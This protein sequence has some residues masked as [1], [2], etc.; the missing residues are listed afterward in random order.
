MEPPLDRPAD[1]DLVGLKSEA[2]Q[3]PD[4]LS[5]NYYFNVGALACG[6]VTDTIS[7]IV[8]S[9]VE[10]RLLVAIPSAAWNR[11]VNLRKLPAGTLE[12]V[13]S[14]NV[15]VASEEDRQEVNPELS[16][17]VW[18]GW[19]KEE[20]YGQIDFT[21]LE[22]VTIPFVAKDSEETC[23]PYAEALVGVAEERFKLDLGMKAD[24][25]GD[26][27]KKFD[28]LQVSLERLIHQQEGKGESG[29]QSPFEEVPAPKGI[30][31]N[32]GKVG[33]V[34]S[35]A[36]AASPGP[37]PGLSEVQ[38]YPGLDAATVAAAIQ[39]GV[40][41]E[42]LQS[43]S[44]VLG[45]SPGKLADY[46]RPDGARGELAQAFEDDAE[47]EE[48][49]LDEEESLGQSKQLSSAIVKLTDI[50]AKLTSSTSSSPN[51]EEVLE[52]SGSG[53]GAG[54]AGDISS[55]LGRK[56]AAARR[57][58]Q[59][60]FLHDP[61]QIWKS[62][63]D[64]MA[65][66]FNMQTSAPNATSAFSARGWCEHRSK[67]QPYIRTCRWVWGIAGVLD[68]LRAGMHD[69]ARARCCLLIAAAEQESLDHGSFLLSQEFLMEPPVPLSSFQAHV[70]PDS[71]EMATTRLL[72]ARWIEA[73]ADRLKQVDTYLEM[74][75][76]VNFKPRQNQS[77][78]TSQ[79]PKGKGK[80]KSKGKSKQKPSADG[81]PAPQT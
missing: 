49:G 76:K 55:S 41:K 42:H 12:K 73:Y 39:A 69:Q 22:L 26:L 68:S 3:S 28:L 9:F 7:I 18:L 44:K 47:D 62:I 40:P 27:E 29:F 11:K 75:R 23:W 48:D 37:P 79:E 70:L 50:M 6:G 74:R 46:P 65:L 51:L 61:S 13:I 15:A 17:N 78:E 63:E 16:C 56:H 38:A 77:G 10:D 1:L 5:V 67:I 32:K 31:K 58:L 64:N 72:D 20:V 81:D 25:L 4:S 34:P 24:R 14:A 43:M 2:V 21:N 60:T 45:K 52:Q 54:S 35:S 33:G 36:K 66:D 71:M 57:A 80:G 53:G 59:R 8:V 30:L 19:L